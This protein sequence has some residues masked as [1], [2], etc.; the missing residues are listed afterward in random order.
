[1]YNALCCAAADCDAKL[2]Y[3]ERWLCVSYGTEEMQCMACL[4]SVKLASG[5]VQLRLFGPE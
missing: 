3:N 1:M 2:G 5:K 4:Y